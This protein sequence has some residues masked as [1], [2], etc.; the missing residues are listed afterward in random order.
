[1]SKRKKRDLGNRYETS[2]KTKDKTAKGRKGIFDFDSL[3]EE[4][5][6]LK[7]KSEGTKELIIIPYEVK[8]KNH[9]LVHSNDKEIGEYD[10]VMD[11][12]VHR[13]IGAAGNDY[14]CLEKNYGKACSI[15]TEMRRAYKENDKEKGNSLY[16]SRRCY[17]NV[18][19]VNNIEDG[20]RIFHVSHDFFE[21]KL[22][23]ASNKYATDGPY[24]RFADINRGKII[25]FDAVKSKFGKWDFFKFEDFCFKDR[26]KIITAE[27]VDKY[28]D[29]AVSFDELL[30]I[31][32]YEEMEN[33]LY[34]N[35]DEEESYNE[36]E[37][38]DE[39]DE[40]IKRK[41]NREN[42]GEKITCPNKFV[43]GEEFDEYEECDECE[44]ETWRAC[45]KEK[46]SI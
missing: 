29:K 35:S 2:Y 30:I 9:P 12:F 33:I 7:F 10:Y 26:N 8:S 13:F 21:E 39:E 24:V 38:I 6:F 17:Y 5:N 3:N 45:K 19:D 20:L 43:F 31:P 42:K 36:E 44:K 32:T 37:Q 40:P 11:I 22:I 15:C 1:M 18:I 16:A 4:I 14:V 34:E 46:R 27:E 41:K 23:R 28:V 25:V